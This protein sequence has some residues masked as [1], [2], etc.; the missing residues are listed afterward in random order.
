MMGVCSW[1]L[2]P[3]SPAELAQLAAQCGVGAVQLAL[4]P[5]R[6]R[7]WDVSDLRSVL[8]VSGL[9]IASGMFEPVGEDYSTITRIRETGGVL[10]DSTWEENRRRAG[11]AAAIAEELGI[12]LVTLH[13]GVIPHGAG[14]PQRGR[15][16]DR[17]RVLVELFAERGVSLGL[18]TGQET[19]ES[20]SRFLDELGSESVGVNFDPAN[21]ILYGTGD[22]IAAL[23]QLLPRVVQ[24]H[25]KD[26]IPSAR[27][28]DWGTEVPVGAGAVDWPAFMGLVASGVRII[29]TMLER[30]A[31]DAR[32]EDIR[33]G[34]THLGGVRPVVSR[35]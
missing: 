17:L 16:L 11:Q 28:D 32:V 35:A 1:S 5:L 10:P 22:P 19:A 27:A 3:G 6:S 20:L 13:A 12:G 2:R 29:D 24:V 30:E 4:E 8:E 9:R 18:E 31:G 15:V 21:M 7:A 26:A 23:R 34:L 33:R 14:D 25:L